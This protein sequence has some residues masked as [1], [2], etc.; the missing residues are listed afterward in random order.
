M[1]YQTVDNRRAAEGHRHRLHF[2]H[3]E[4]ELDFLAD[5]CCRRDS[6]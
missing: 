3:P 2:P 5:R 6:F 4:I 1:R